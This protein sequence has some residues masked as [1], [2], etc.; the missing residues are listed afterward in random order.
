VKSTICCLSLA[1]SLTSCGHQS[2]ADQTLLDQ[3]QL[4]QDSAQQQTHKGVMLIADA[5]IPPPQ[6]AL[7]IDAI[8]HRLVFSWQPD[9][10]EQLANLYQHDSLTGEEI[11]IRGD[12]TSNTTKISVPSNTPGRA[13]HDEK[14]RLE[15]CDKTDCVSSVRMT[16]DTLVAKTSQ[17]L[18]PSVFIQGERFA[19]S[20]TANHDASMIA[21]TLPAEGAVQIHFY[22][23]QQWVENSP[24][25]LALTTTQE[26]FDVS[27]SYTGDTLAA[28]VLDN[29]DDQIA[30]HVQILERLGETWISTSKLTIP[31]GTTIDNAS[32]I[33][34]SANADE[35]YLHTPEQ[36]LIYRRHDIDWRLQPLLSATPNGLLAAT[37]VSKN[38]NRVHAVVRQTGAIWFVIYQL[39]SE[40]NEPEWIETH[41]VS[42]QGID[43]DDDVALHNHT[44]GTSIIVAGWD[45]A[46]QLERSAVLWRYQ[47]FNSSRD[48]QDP[49]L[50][51]TDSL[52]TAPTQDETAQLR[53]SASANLDHVVLGWHS[54]AGDD[55][56]VKTFTFNAQ[57]QRFRVALELPH[58]LSTLAKQSFAKDV[59]LSGDGST[60]LVATLPGTATSPENRAGELH[61]FR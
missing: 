59:L 12:M 7:S 10:S 13:W 61:V 40:S 46:T 42:L 56:L 4:D 55:A 28:L 31:G 45:T 30:A 47:L 20:V 37:A 29:N 22:N 35:L 2:E 6:P 39:Q 24:V 19:S 34:L 44:D 58:A 26:L 5:L 53:F 25:S 23:Q 36:L 3:T 50:T 41:R 33:S 60:L 9:H 48:T 8:A 49:L 21:S 38:P 15:L 14:F 51:V 17:T 11:L 27:S 16:V 32:Q 18:R 43:S 52:R 57:Q 54:P 1:V